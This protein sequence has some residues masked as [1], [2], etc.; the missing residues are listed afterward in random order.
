MKRLAMITLALAVVGLAVQAQARLPWACRDCGCSNARKVCKLVPNVT[1]ITKF[2]YCVEC[3]DFCVNG[4]SKC[5][6]TQQ[7]CDCHGTHC[8]KIMQ[9]TCCEVLTRAKVIKRPVVTE[10]NGWKCVVETVCRGCGNCCASVDATEA[11]TKAYVAAAEQQGILQVSATEPIQME[12][13]AVASDARVAA[14]KKASGLSS[15]LNVFKR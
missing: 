1:K 10:K 15:L 6:G 5:I 11:E 3:E 2:E 9:P 7:V 13:P 14:E 4:R 8:E 12:L